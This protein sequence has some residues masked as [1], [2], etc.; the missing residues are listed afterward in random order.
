MTA[1]IPESFHD[2]LTGPVYVNLATEMAD[3][4]VQV[5]PVWCGFADGDILVNSAKGRVKDRNM[6]ERPRATVLAM[7]PNNP[8][9][10]LEA[11]CDVVE[12][13]EDGADDHIDDLAELYLGQRPYPFR[14]EGEVRVIYRL[15]PVRVNVWDPA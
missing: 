14:A 2:L 8:F 5:N 13:T 1:T 10:W 7:D 3:G 15:R 9:R 11:R 12:V 4:R 6:R